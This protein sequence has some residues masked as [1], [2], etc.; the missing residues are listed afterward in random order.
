MIYY[1]RY[2]N[3]IWGRYRF[4]RGSNGESG[5]SRSRRLVKQRTFLIANENYALAA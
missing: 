1:L 5:V 4:A 2:N 3:I